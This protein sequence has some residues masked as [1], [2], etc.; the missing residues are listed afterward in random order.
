MAND[1]SV[2]IV[3]A[4]PVGTRVNINLNS[5]MVITAVLCCVK[6]LPVLKRDFQSTQL[7]IS[8]TYFC[9]AYCAIAFFVNLTGI[10]YCLSEIRAQR[11]LSSVSKSYVKNYQ[12]GDVLRQAKKKKTEFLQT[13]LGNLNFFASWMGCHVGNVC[14][15][16]FC[17]RKDII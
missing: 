6:R 14:T 7:P 8:K 12:G 1:G 13:C 17:D 4:V 10:I 5:F 15:V 2:V 9:R 3:P 11:R 16:G